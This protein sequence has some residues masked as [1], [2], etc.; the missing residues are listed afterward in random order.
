[1]SDSERSESGG[2]GP[3]RPAGSEP[4]S[5]ALPVSET[6]NCFEAGRLAGFKTVPGSFLN[7]KFPNASSRTSAGV[8]VTSEPSPHR[9]HYN[10]LLSRDRR[11]PGGG[12]LNS[13][14]SSRAGP[15][16]SVML[17]TRDSDVT[18][19]RDGPRDSI[20]TLTCLF[21]PAVPA[22]RSIVV[23]PPKQQFGRRVGHSSTQ[24]LRPAGPATGR[25]S[26]SESTMAAPSADRPGPSATVPRIQ[27][28]PG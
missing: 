24:R 28:S 15:A 10:D 20:V 27:P 9:L 8:H 3:G 17:V 5:L 23:V 12:S 6:L 14:P 18:H 16:Y 2:L 1:M 7:I 11:G 22:R 13:P 26:S 19:R 4:H 21:S 25:R